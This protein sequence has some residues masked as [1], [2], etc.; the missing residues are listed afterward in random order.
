M[1]FKMK[2]PL[3]LVAVMGSAVVALCA[4]ASA[5]NAYL[6]LVHAAPGRNIVAPAPTAVLPNPSPSLPV[7]VSA[8]GSC[9]AQGVS[10]GDI[11]GPLSGPPGT[12]VLLVTQADSGTP[13]TGATVFSAVVTFDPGA[14]YV[15]VLS[16]DANGELTGT[17]YTPDFS[18]IPEGQGRLALVNAS[19]DQVFVTLASTGPYPVPPSALT[20]FTPTFGIFEAGIW[21][22][23]QNLLVG[24]TNVEIQQRAFYIYA[25]AGS[26]ANGS[27]QLIGPKKVLGVF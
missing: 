26:V 18:S 9:F 10:Y 20:V 11:A 17:V 21:D 14:T 25:I 22:S 2:R 6:Y 23:G 24:P 5:Q 13:C 12:Y 1:E 7:D 3:A 15:G 4:Q 27:I 16:V 8:N 19:L